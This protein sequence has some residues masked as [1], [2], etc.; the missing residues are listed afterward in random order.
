MIYPA[1]PAADVWVSRGTD[2]IYRT[3]WRITG[4][5]PIQADISNAG[6]SLSVQRQIR[7]IFEFYELL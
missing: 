4:R 5:K 6:G 2:P 3:R 7:H 1:T